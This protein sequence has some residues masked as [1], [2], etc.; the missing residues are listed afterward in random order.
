MRFHAGIPLPTQSRTWK[1]SKI[2]E[3]ANEADATLG[4]AILGDS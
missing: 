2:N 3:E 4:F 1:E